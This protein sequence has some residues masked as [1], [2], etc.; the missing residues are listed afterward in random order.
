MVK[1]GKYKLINFTHLLALSKKKLSKLMNAHLTQSKRKC[2]NK[3]QKIYS[4]IAEA[5]P[6]PE[7]LFSF[8]LR[9]K[10][11]EELAEPGF[12]ETKAVLFS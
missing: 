4:E 2:F 10:N 11:V 9:N 7:F 5:E 3:T 6:Q 8:L 1:H 12:I